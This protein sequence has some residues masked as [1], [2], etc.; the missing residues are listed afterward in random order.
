MHLLRNQEFPVPGRD[1]QTI[2]LELYESL[3]D[4]LFIKSIIVIF[5]DCQCIYTDSRFLY[6]VSV[7]TNRG[8]VLAFGN[9]RTVPLSLLNL[10]YLIL[11]LFLLQVFYGYD[12]LFR[13][14]GNKRLD[15]QG[16][17][18]NYKNIKSCSQFVLRRFQRLQIRSPYL[19]PSSTRK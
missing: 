7:G 5:L 15:L 18:W 19:S 14:R 10:L 17:K 4:Y 2:L 3:F 13:V 9:A 8:T 16:Q 12:L 1:L 11:I 6:L